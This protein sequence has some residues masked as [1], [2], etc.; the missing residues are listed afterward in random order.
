MLFDDW[1][2][3]WSS[4]DIEILLAL[5]T[6]DCVYEDVAM[7]A[8]HQGK[9]ALQ[10]FATAVFAAIPDFKISLTDGFVAGD[11]GAAE[12]TMCGT[13]RGDLPGVPAT[14]KPFSVRGAT[15]CLSGPGAGAF[16]PQS[17]RG[18]ACGARR[19]GALG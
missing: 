6:D 12:W 14:G 10:E 1:A 2:S 18:V 7:G 15:V 13:H 17:A 5:C 19:I 11:H 16:S 4:H 9:Q 8:V 3:A